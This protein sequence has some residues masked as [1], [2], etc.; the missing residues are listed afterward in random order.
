MGVGSAYTG[1]RRDSVVKPEDKPRFTLPEKTALLVFPG[2]YAG[3]E[4]R[5]LLSV[6]FA[7]LISL[8]D[9]IS[10]EE[11]AM[12]AFDLFAERVLIDW[13][14]DDKDGEIPAS[15]DGM[16]RID[17]L[18]GVLL[19]REWVKAMKSPPDP[20]FEPSANGRSDVE[21]SIPTESLSSSLPS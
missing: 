16:R 7:V 10:D 5:T 4:V 11:S 17:P 15:S 18:F 14:L 20:L 2:D 19:I 21:A 6:P 3:A 1:A 8:Q 12:E 9:Q 13:N